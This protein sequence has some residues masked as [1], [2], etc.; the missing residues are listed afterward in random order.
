MKTC[1]VVCTMLIKRRRLLRRNHATAVGCQQF[2]KGSKNIE[3]KLC[4]NVRIQRYYS[5]YILVCCLEAT[6]CS[7]KVF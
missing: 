5:F 7:K 6:W 2:R 3:R 4:L 1:A